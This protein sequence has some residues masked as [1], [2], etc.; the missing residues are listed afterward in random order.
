MLKLN[1]VEVSMKDLREG[2]IRIQAMC[3]FCSGWHEM[4]V[5]LSDLKAT[6]EIEPTDGALLVLRDS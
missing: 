5:K 1:A 3:P 6:L 2:P 4:V